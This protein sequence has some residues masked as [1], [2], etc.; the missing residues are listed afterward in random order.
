MSKKNI[1]VKFWV[2]MRT[3]CD[4]FEPCNMIGGKQIPHG[5]NEL[6]Y[7]KDITWLFQKKWKPRQA[8]K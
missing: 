7:L 1:R 6:I 2:L 3:I 5:Q 8:F 4:A